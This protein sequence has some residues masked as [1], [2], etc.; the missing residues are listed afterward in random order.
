MKVAILCFKGVVQSSVFGPYDI[1]TRTNG[2]IEQFDPENQ[3]RFDVE[4]LN[5]NENQ[6]AGFVSGMK[7]WKDKGKK[8]DLVIIPSMDF[9]IV[10]KVLARESELVEWVK[11]QYKHGAEVASICMGAFL[12]AETGLLVGKMATTHWLGRDLFLQM[13]PSIA[14]VDD[15]IITD[16]DRIYTSGGAFSFTS[17][18]IYLVEK[19]VSKDIATIAT[20]IFMIHLHD[21]VQQVYSIFTLQKDHADDTIRRIQEKIERNFHQS[22]S[23]ENLAMDANMSV[24]NFIRRFKKAVG[25]SPLEYIQRVR[26][27]AAKKYLIEQNESVERVCLSVGYDD[28]SAF[29][30]IFKRFTGTTP[31]VYRKK[32]NLLTQPEYVGVYAS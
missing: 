15:K 5:T 27:E 12:L 19:Y 26:I 24:R 22:L 10:G 7:S 1:L 23:V 6:Q 17:L 18:I 3:F 30:K 32:Y 14:L 28:L 2:M 29:R 20:R 16:Q 31:S 9:E 11:M 4:I 8:Y 25:N 13:Y 21:S